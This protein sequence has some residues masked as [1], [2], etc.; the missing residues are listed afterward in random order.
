[1]GVGTHSSL[2][3]CLVLLKTVIISSVEVLINLAASN[4]VPLNDGYHKNL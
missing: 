4:P 3:Y 1:M 2:R